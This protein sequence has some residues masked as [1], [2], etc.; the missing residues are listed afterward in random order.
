MMNQVEEN[1]FFRTY[2]A[3]LKHEIKN[4]DIEIGMLNS[5]A[6]E[7]KARLNALK[8][9]DKGDRK[10]FKKEL[11]VQELMEKNHIANETIHR[12]RDQL[13]RLLSQI[14]SKPKTIENEGK[15]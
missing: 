4:K 11:L 7:L 5:E 1:A 14:H 6:E 2:I 10:E 3:S 13:D 8:S 15:S 12:M 9:F